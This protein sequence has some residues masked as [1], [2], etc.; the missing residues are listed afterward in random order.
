MRWKICRLS[1][2]I[3]S[4]LNFFASLIA[5]SDFPEEVGPAMIIIFDFTDGIFIAYTMNNQ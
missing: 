5:A 4:P 1:A 3:I 2:E